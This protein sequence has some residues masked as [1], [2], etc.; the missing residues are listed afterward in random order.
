MLLALLIRTGVDL[1]G[2][3]DYV[4]PEHIALLKVSAR[5]VK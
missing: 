5:R 4:L 1:L 3:P 2:L